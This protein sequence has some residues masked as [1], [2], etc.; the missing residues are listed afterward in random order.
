MKKRQIKK[1]Q[2]PLVKTLMRS[3]GGLLNVVAGME[4]EGIS[5]KVEQGEWSGKTK[6]GRD[7]KVKYGYGIKVGLDDFVK[8]LKEKNLSHGTDRTSK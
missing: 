3:I 7:L 2:H 6:D 5:E 8:N 1:S 4:K